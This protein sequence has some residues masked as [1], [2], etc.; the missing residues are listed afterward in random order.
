[1]F[2]YVRPLVPA[3]RV[4]EYELYRSVYCGLCRTMGTV[5]GQ[6]SRMT[7]S[8]DFCFLAL[9]RM[10]LTE[11]EPGFERARCLMHPLHKRLMAEENASLRYTAVSAA[12]LAECKRLD[13][14]ADEKGSALVKPIL[15]APLT[16]SM[17]YC[18]RRQEPSLTVLF[19][20]MQEKLKSLSALEKNAC[21][22][23]DRA[24]QVFG[25]LLMDLFSFGL[26][27]S[28]AEIAKT[29]GLGTGRFI[30]LCDAMDDLAEDIRRERY[31]PIAKL[32]GDMA[33][34]ENGKPSPIVLESFQ[35][36]ALLDLEKTGLA[37]ELLPPGP[38]TEIVKNIVYLG[39]PDTVQRIVRGEN[40]IKKIRISEQD[41]IQETV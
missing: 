34:G 8:Y 25:E 6:L 31:N 21:D 33:L 40:G 28:K 37:A 4:R 32:W 2:G 18:S 26:N 20:Q 14:M 41:K 39:M 5:S 19:P 27:G 13:D 17:F 22:S 11:N 9:V 7:L 3:L 1:M 30:Y 16:G 38:L 23:P 29:I 15:M 24:A 12:Y 10:I 35:T 36:A